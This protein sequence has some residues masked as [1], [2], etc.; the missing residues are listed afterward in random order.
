MRC[1]VKVPRQAPNAGEV[2]PRDLRGLFRSSWL[3]ADLPL[4]VVSY[5]GAGFEMRSRWCGL[6]MMQQ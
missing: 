4:R 1:Q 3:M 5:R 2:L 6:R